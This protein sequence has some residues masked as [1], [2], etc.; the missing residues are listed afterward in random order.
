MRMK[1]L[2]KGALVGVPQ[3]FSLGIVTL[4]HRSE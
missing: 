4:L 2:G 3:F 1:S